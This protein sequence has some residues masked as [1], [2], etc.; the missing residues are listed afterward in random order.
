MASAGFEILVNRVGADVRLCSTKLDGTPHLEWT[1]RVMEASPDRLMLYQAVGTPIGTW[2]EVWIPGYDA[3]VHFW[4][5]KWFNVIQALNANSA[6]RGYYCN[7]ITP[8]QTVG[9][10]LRWNDLD[11]DVRVQADGTYRILDEDEWARNAE[12][13]GYAPGILR[14]ARRAIE[15]LMASIERRAFPFDRLRS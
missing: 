1:C 4:R 5:D 10:E 13:I 9:D 12:R 6:P 2:K 3:R 15:E 8:A 14:N 7:I 11:L